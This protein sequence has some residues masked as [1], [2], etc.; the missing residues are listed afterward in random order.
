MAKQRKVGVM[1]ESFRLGVKE[2]IEK[3]AEIG[4]DG[5]QI[6]VTG[7]Q[8]APENMTAS[9][10]RDF[11]KLVADQGLVISALCADYF[12]GFLNPETNPETVEKT[13]ACMDLAADLGI[14]VITSHIGTL[15]EDEDTP[16]WRD[17]IEALTEVAEHAEKVGVHMASETGPESGAVLLRFLEN[18]PG[19]TI[20]VNYDPANLVMRGFD[21]I[22][23]VEVLGDYIYH[24]HAK[25]GTREPCREVPLGEG[26]VDF[27]RWVAAL[28]AIGYDGF[29]T[30]EREVGDDPVT[31]IVNAVRYLRTL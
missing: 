14:D 29:L 24:T 13:K 27:P 6:Y 31:D 8:M 12:K 22:G 17:G 19:K 28:D 1:I 20:G 7:G 9:A 30:I 25:D 3:A 18:I 23:D 15:P 16:E 26:D 10:R 5:F 4:A 11:R 21:Q 2:G